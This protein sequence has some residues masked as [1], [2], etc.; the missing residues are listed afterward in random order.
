ML[1]SLLVLV[2]ALAYANGAND[3]FN[4]VATLFGGGTTDYR[5]ALAWA[6]LTTMA[7]SALA[8]VLAADLVSTFRGRGL[9]PDAVAVEPTFVVAVAASAGLTVLLATW[10][11]LP[12]STTHAIVGG[13]LG[14]GLVANGGAIS[15]RPL[16]STFLLPLL[17]SPLL[18]CALAFVMYPALRSGR[19]ALG[20]T[21]QSCACVGVVQAEVIAA[22][23]TLAMGSRD[24]V[25]T[26]GHL[27]DCSE[28]YDGRMLGLDAGRALDVLHHVSSGAVGFARGL[29][30]T[31]KI[32]ALLL[33]A[34]LL[35]PGLGV[36]LV[37][38][39]MAA[40]GW[41]GARRV[42]ETMSCRITRMSPGQGLAANMVTSGLVV[43][44]SCLG[45]PVSTTHVSVGALFGIGAVTGTA[46]TRTVLGILLAWLVTLPLAAALAAA[47]HGLLRLAG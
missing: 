25:A 17:C 32:V 21:R 3:T 37:A 44:A 30:D 4:G 9:V 13:L 22:G 36:A 5:G 27:A 39:V 47:M 31:P 43:L 20:I 38:A 6:L 14:A 23:G 1:L 40:G 18:A 15:A 8:L 10:L 24:V 33:A 19:R 2:L 29:N 35:A 26:T 41:L 34:P 42:A 46:R 45:L 16:A 7:G 11:G 28:R 12:V